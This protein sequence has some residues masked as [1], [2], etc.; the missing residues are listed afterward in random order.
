MLSASLTDSWQVCGAA[1]LNL[2]RSV[3]PWHLSLC[4]VATM[5]FSTA[6]KRETFQGNRRLPLTVSEEKCKPTLS[7]LESVSLEYWNF[8]AEFFLEVQ[9]PSW[10]LLLTLKVNFILTRCFNYLFPNHKDN[11]SHFVSSV[12]KYPDIYIFFYPLVQILTIWFVSVLFYI[13]LLWWFEQLIKQFYIS[14]SS[15]SVW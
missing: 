14:L 1:C 5:C 6:R 15:N 8:G 12:F 4:Y 13:H 11:P 9:F 2:S 7:L 10:V 3:E